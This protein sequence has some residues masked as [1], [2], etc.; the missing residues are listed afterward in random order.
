MLRACT[1]HT[2]EPAVAAPQNEPATPGNTETVKQY[3]VLTQTVPE[4]CDTLHTHVCD[5]G[6]APN[7][8]PLPP[9]PAATGVAVATVVA[10]AACFLLHKRGAFNSV[11]ENLKQRVQGPATQSQG[12]VSTL[13]TSHL[14]LNF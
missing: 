6:T 4:L 2:Y 10:G 5:A 1:V 13:N 9:V 14:C 7:T 8:P 3:L 11:W 12:T